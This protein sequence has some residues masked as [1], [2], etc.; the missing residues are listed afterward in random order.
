MLTFFAPSHFWDL[1]EAAS[2]RIAALDEAGPNYTLQDLVWRAWEHILDVYF[3][4]RAAQ[5]GGMRY[6]IDRE[7]YRGAPPNSTWQH[8]PDVIVVR[9]SNVTAQPGQRL[10]AVKRDL[11]WVE[12]KAP[13]LSTPYDWKQ[14]MNEALG[15]LEQ[16]HGRNAPGGPRRVFFILATGMYWMHFL[17]DPTRGP[18]NSNPTPLSVL[19]ADQQGLWP[20]NDDVYPVP[21][22]A[23][24]H[25]VQASNGGLIIDT[26][27]AHTL[28]YWSLDSSGQ[29]IRHMAD[30]QLVESFLALVQTTPYNGSNPADFL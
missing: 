6:E 10:T 2:L 24:R 19:T 9:I 25:I 12:C 11:L 14:V 4:R 16:A 17:Y 26:S 20:V 28:D 18:A 29:N 23:S 27:R 22:L 15:R 5:P 13:I 21:G 1:E 8:K 3:P 30:L 7:A